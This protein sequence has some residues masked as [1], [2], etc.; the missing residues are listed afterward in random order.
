LSVGE[1]KELDRTL[2]TAEAELIS[3]T[4]RLKDPALTRA[5][6]DPDELLVAAD[7][8]SQTASLA[9]Q[10]DKDAAAALVIAE[11]TSR[12]VRAA[13]EQLRSL[14]AEFLAA[15]QDA[16]AV[17]RVADLT[18]AGPANLRGVDLPTYVLIRRF[19]EVIA[20]A[21]DRLRP[22]SAGRYLLEH[23]DTKEEAR[24]R[25]TGLA[26][27]VRDNQ[28]GEARP[29][30][31][32]SGGETFYVSLALALGLADVVTAE[33]GGAGLETLFVDEGFGSLDGESLEAVL[34]Q[35]VRL[36]DGGRVVGLVSHVEALKQAIPER[37][38]ARPLP[39]G[40]STLRVRA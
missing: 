19:E 37:I 18:T 40:G 13:A 10:S 28:T 12:L 36:R 23:S 34:T 33:A 24:Q 32:L 14:T 30:K 27:R 8:A 31:T 6:G 16:A 25:H 20:A 11:R 21:N 3:V 38:E 7:A 9:Q 1:L 26:L 5:G 4:E 39:G 15:K 22:M 29:P 17:T 35:L 2:K